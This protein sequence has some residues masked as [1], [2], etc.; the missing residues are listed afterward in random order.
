MKSVRWVFASQKCQH[1]QGSGV[2]VA[3]RRT[4]VTFARALRLCVSKVSAFSGIGGSWSRNAELSSLL[5]VRWVVASQKC[6]HSRGSGGSWSRNAELSSLL[7]VRWVVASQKCQHSQGSGGSW[8]R[9]AELSSLLD[10]RGV[11]ASERCQP[12][13]GS[14]VSWSRNAEMWSLL[15]SRGAYAFESVNRLRDRRGPGRE[16][17]NRRGMPLWERLR[18]LGVNPRECLSR[19]GLGA[20]TSTQKNASLRKA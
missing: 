6:Q 1:S 16:T 18:S 9:N 17:Q 11:F 12:S 14:G 4:V 7:D 3:K 15:D 13:R 20:C 19:K 5:D 10:L 8:S 2:L